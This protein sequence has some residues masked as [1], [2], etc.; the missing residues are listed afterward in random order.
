MLDWCEK[1]REKMIFFSPSSSNYDLL[2]FIFDHPLTSR[3]DII[4]I[5]I[6]TRKGIGSVDFV[7]ET[8]PCD[9]SL[10][11]SMFTRRNFGPVSVI[12]LRRSFSYSEID[13]FPFCSTHGTKKSLE[14]ST[15]DI[16]YS[17]LHFIKYSNE[18]L[19]AEIKI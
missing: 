6:C 9:P 19:T 11:H 12:F 4:L 8:L 16:P 14:M 18:A 3:S 2:T 1:K 10:L 13:Y 15:G 7:L 5:S 17:N